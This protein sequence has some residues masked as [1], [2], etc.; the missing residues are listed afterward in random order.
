M[1]EEPGFIIPVGYL[2]K[3]NDVFYVNL[4]KYVRWIT[5]LSILGP[6]ACRSGARHRHPLMKVLP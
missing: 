2:Y 5:M 6:I 3:L 4:E 1:Q